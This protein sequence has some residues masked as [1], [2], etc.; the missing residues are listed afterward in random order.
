MAFET[1]NGQQF[2]VGNSVIN[3]GEYFFPTGDAYLAGF[4]GAVGGYIYRMGAIFWKPVIRVD[5]LNMEYP[6]LPSLGLGSPDFL[7]KRVYC[8]PTPLVLPTAAMEVTRNITTGYEACLTSSIQ[9]QFGSKTNVS[10]KIPMI[11][12]A[13]GSSEASWGL[14]ASITNT[15]CEKHTETEER[16]LTF[17]SYN[18]PAETS[19]DYVFTQWSGTLQ[20]LLFSATVRVTLNDSST[21]NR[22]E[23]GTYSGVAYTNTYEFYDNHMHPVTSCR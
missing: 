8:N 16:K 9:T 3:D 5:Y 1:S 15:N 18:I 12:A 11:E 13:G 21:Y 20:D 6:T 4:A 10:G 14:T 2:Q 23:N 22:T 19:F 7:S 17:P